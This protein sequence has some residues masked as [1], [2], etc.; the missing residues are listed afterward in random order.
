MH[1]T[2][3][4]DKLFTI[5]IDL[6]THTREEQAAVDREEM[7]KEEVFPDVPRCR[8]LLLIVGDTFVIGLRLSQVL[9]GNIKNELVFL[10]FAM[11]S[12]VSVPR[13]LFLLLFAVSGRLVQ[14]FTDGEP[15]NPAG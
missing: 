14:L 15:I 1:Q 4:A 12:R 8:W 5:L 10:H 2:E 13:P 7:Q 9:D 6:I 11:M 3:I